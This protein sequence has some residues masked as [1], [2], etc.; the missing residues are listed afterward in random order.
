MSIEVVAVGDEIL[1]GTTQ[2]TNSAFVARELFAAGLA[3]SRVTVVGDAAP[4][5]LDAFAAALGRARA[6]VVTGGLGPTVDDRTKEVVAAHF[7]AP[8]EL[9]AAGLSVGANGAAPVIGATFSMPFA[10]GSD[11]TGARPPR[12]PVVVVRSALGSPER[13]G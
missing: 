5:L 4:D 8:L 6:I 13:T 2:D 9:D 1:M 7:G 10:V 11:A 12:R 3:L